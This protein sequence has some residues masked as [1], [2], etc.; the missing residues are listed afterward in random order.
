MAQKLRVAH[1][2]P[3]TQTFDLVEGEK[4]QLNP[5]IVLKKDPRWQET[6]EEFR[7]TSLFACDV[8]TFGT[9]SWHPL[10]FRYG[11]PRLIQ[12]GLPSKKVLIADLGGFSDEVQLNVEGYEEFLEILGQKLADYS[13]VV[14]GHNFKFD[15][16]FLMAYF[17]F[18][19]RQVR[20][21]MI[22]S[23]CVWGGVGVVPSGGTSERQML[24]HSLAKVCER[25]GIPIDK[26]KQTSNWAWEL[27]NLQLNY[28]A[29]DVIVLFEVY[30]KF[31]KI[32]AE[33]KD[34]ITGQS[35]D[36][37][38]RTEC[39][40]VPVF[41]EMEYRGVPVDLEL[42]DDYIEQHYA[43][44]KEVIKPFT[45]V[46]GEDVNWNSDQ[47]L[48]AALNEQYPKLKLKATSSEVLGPLDIDTTNAVLKARTIQTTVTYLENIKACAFQHKPDQLDSVR[49][50]LKQ[51]APEAT[52]RSSCTGTLSKDSGNQG[53]QLQNPKASSADEGHLPH[54]RDIF[55]CPETHR[56][57]GIDAAASHARICAVL[58][59][60]EILISA[61]SN[62]FDN[63]SML[64][65]DIC[66]IAL[67][68][69]NRLVSLGKTPHSQ[70]ASLQEITKGSPWTFEQIVEKKKEKNPDAI[71][72]RNTAKTLLYSN[73]NAAG[74]LRIEEGLKGKGIAWVTQDTA[75]AMRDSFYE[76]HPELVAFIKSNFE[77]ANAR[78]VDFSD[79]TD[80]NGK[81]I[82]EVYGPY[83]YVTCMLG[84][85]KYLA[86][87]PSRFDETKL[88]VHYAKSCSS[89]WLMTESLLIKRWLADS[90]RLLDNNPQWSGYLCTMSHDE[91]LFCTLAEHSIEAA[92]KIYKI[93][94][95]IFNDAYKII[96]FDE[97]NFKPENCIGR[98]W[99]EIH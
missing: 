58:A 41:A 80:L 57:I 25:L 16:V 66:K 37:A 45:E 84:R 90:L 11:M 98:S 91:G 55:R 63:H 92:T 61:Y 26:S 30:E 67:G 65:S 22:I 33:T 54:P 78:H 71:S 69:Y 46:F 53:A 97:G 75:K 62:G 6:L 49:T 64:A 48:L 34:N 99:S 81:N 83:G 36:F 13:V 7:K 20:D 87:T 56:I 76:R 31:K 42:L 18:K 10:F 14:L 12:V 9:K 51:I 40:A 95:K 32:I 82:E 86:K 89:V 50:F 1:E 70:L 59:N 23:Q 39:D 77:R 88:Q 96:P 17:G 21:S 15:I 68:E 73:I 24:G 5:N 3:F 28:A 35:M 8:E 43:R 60:V 27:S 72:L 93:M 47:Q 38:V 44:L 19:V 94:E 52:G 74:V 2:I 85:R 79:F 4:T 29:A